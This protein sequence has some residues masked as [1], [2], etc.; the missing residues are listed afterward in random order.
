MMSVNGRQPDCGAG[1][2]KG[3]YG[4][5]EDHGPIPDIPEDLFWAVALVSAA[6][7]AP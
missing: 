2:D 5:I 7:P 6:H 4:L 1:L 3:A